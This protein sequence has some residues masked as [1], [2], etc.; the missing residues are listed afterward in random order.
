MSAQAGFHSLERLRAALPLVVIAIVASCDEVREI[1][2]R[3]ESRTPHQEYAE[4]L[5]NA[6]LE[7]TALG[8]DWLFS[9]DSAL[10]HARDVSL[11]YRL[12]GS[13]A[14]SEAPALGLRF[15]L[16]RGQRLRVDVSMDTVQVIQLFID[17]FRAPTDSGQAPRHVESA[18]SRSTFLEA[19]A[20]RDGE[21][22]LRIQPELLRGGDYELSVQVEPALAFPVAGRDGRSVRSYFGADRD[23][24]RRRHQGIDIFAP[25]GTPALAVSTGFVRRVGTNSLGGNVVWVWDESRGHSYYYAH[26]DSQ[27]VTFGERV[28]AGDTLGFVGNTGNARST[29]PHLHFGIYAPGEG[30]VDPLPFVTLPRMPVD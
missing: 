4:A 30:P 1:G 11:P 23:A 5:R 10:R 19:E 15:P 7:Q 6:G 27:A 22:L 26:L 3:L 12:E 20:R 13:L 25:R 14:A 16:R 17:L 24:G 21:Y 18:E 2:E 8:R 9:S 29:A 28:R